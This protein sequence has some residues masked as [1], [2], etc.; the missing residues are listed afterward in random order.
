MKHPNKS[1]IRVY[2]NKNLRIM[3]FADVIS[4]LLSFIAALYIRNDLLAPPFMNDESFFQ[5]IT[6]FVLAKISV[7]Y[8]F[9]LYKGMWRYTSIVDM[10]SIVK[11]NEAL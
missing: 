4:I 5:I 6:L 9:G 1:K 2:S 7:F 10:F 8:F 11:A 3:L